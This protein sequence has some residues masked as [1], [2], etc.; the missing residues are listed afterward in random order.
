MGGETVTQVIQE[1]VEKTSGKRIL[2]SFELTG[3]LPSTTDTFRDFFVKMIARDV[4]E[5]YC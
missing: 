5:A 1:Y 4:K 3:E 2:P